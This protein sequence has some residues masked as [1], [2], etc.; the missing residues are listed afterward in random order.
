VEG[1]PAERSAS[2]NAPVLALE[3]RHPARPWLILAATAGALLVTPLIGL[4]PGLGL[5]AFVLLRFVER[6]SWRMSV[7]VTVALVVLSWL[8]F[9]QLLEVNLPWGAFG[10]L[11]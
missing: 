11:G 1:E 4:I 8:V 2:E 5:M 6:E 10:G 3:V 9:D 7:V